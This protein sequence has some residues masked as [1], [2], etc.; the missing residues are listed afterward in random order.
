[1]R[2]VVSGLDFCCNISGKV[3]SKLKFQKKYACDGYI[4]TIRN[5]I[6]TCHHCFL[7]SS[8]STHAHTHTCTHTIHA[9]KQYI[10]THNTYTH[11]NTHTYM[12]THNTYTHHNTHSVFNMFTIAVPVRACWQG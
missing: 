10:H 1:M 8:L 2:K 3:M 5:K 11:H 9:H 6:P 12:H 7:S 4:M